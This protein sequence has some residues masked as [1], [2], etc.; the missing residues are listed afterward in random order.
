MNQRARI[1]GASF[2]LL[3]QLAAPQS[4]IMFLTVG[5][6]DARFYY[7]RGQS[8]FIVQERAVD[9]LSSHGLI[10]RARGSPSPIYRITT[11]GLEYLRVST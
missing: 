6:D 2:A 10:A 7:Q 4:C 5:F 9:S 3:Q 11:K 1:S 8:H